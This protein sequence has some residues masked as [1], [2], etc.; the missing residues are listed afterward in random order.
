MLQILWRYVVQNK[1]RKS[2]NLLIIH[3]FPFQRNFD[4]CFC[5][6]DRKLKMCN[7]NKNNRYY[8]FHLLLIDLEFF[9]CIGW[10]STWW[11]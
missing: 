10:K 2:A 4:F 1:K 5:A 9:E 11:I 8:S 6:V 7:K 3:H